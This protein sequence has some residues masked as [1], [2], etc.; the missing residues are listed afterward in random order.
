MQNI[1]YKKKILFFRGNWKFLT[2]YSHAPIK[3]SPPPPLLRVDKK[4]NSFSK[5][6]HGGAWKE[7]DEEN[8]KAYQLQWVSAALQRD[9]DGYGGIGSANLQCRRLLPRRQHEAH[10]WYAMDSRAHQR[11]MSRRGKWH[12]EYY[13]HHHRRCCCCVF[14]TLFICQLL[15]CLLAVAIEFYYRKHRLKFV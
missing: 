8:N 13:H 2:F 12:A 11:R 3:P 7:E 15:V 1:K 5:A 4:A 9:G 10:A 14:S 6:A